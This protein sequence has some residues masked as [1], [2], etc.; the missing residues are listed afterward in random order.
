[1]AL[2]GRRNGF[3]TL[4]MWRP[5]FVVIIFPLLLSF[6]TLHGGMRMVVFVINLIALAT[7]IWIATRFSLAG[8]LLLLPLVVVFV[9]FVAVAD[10]GSWWI[11]FA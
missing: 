3:A 8:C 9:A 5:Y 10:C 2:R 4:V 6:S 7:T 1:M 11:P